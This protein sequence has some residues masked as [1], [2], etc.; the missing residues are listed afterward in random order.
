MFDDLFDDELWMF[1]AW[2]FVEEGL[3]ELEE[4]ED[5]ES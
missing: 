3:K 5:K 1:C 4:E 2:D